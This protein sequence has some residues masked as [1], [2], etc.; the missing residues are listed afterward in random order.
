MEILMRSP[1]IMRI[2]YTF[3]HLLINA[4]IEYLLCV[5]TAA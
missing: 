2:K 5:D 1:F 4:Q 3:I